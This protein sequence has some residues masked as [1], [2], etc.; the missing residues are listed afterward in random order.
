MDMPVDKASGP[1]GFPGAFYRVC[2]DIIKDDLLC[3]FRQLF[4]L[5]ARLL[6]KIND[7]LIVLI[8]KKKDPLG[9]GDYRPISLI[10]SLMKTI[11]K[12]ISRRLAPRLPALISKC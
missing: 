5:N 1:D 10:H 2:W 7:A 12:V 3:V 11:M 9:I 6:H 4:N 8:P